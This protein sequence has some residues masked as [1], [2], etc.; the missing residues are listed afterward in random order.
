[1]VKI[2]HHFIQIVPLHTKGA[3]R[4]RKPR[5]RMH[6]LIACR[7]NNTVVNAVL[8]AFG[9]R[10]TTHLFF[11]CCEIATNF[12]SYS[13]HFHPLPAGGLLHTDFP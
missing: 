1:M 10:A 4:N 3:K 6:T 11:K 8:E 9:A 12:G 5:A 13:G 2:L 7:P